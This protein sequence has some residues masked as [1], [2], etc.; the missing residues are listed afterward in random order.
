[1][2]DDVMKWKCFPYFCPFVRGIHL[3]CG[4]PHKGPVMW[5]FD[6]GFVVSLVNKLSN[7]QSSCRW[8][9]LNVISPKWHTCHRHQTCLSYPWGQCTRCG[10]IIP[11]TSLCLSVYLKK[12]LSLVQ[13]IIDAWLLVISTRPL[14]EPVL[15]YCG[16]D[17]C[18][19]IQ[20]NFKP[21]YN[22][23]HTRKWTWN[24]VCKTEAVLSQ[25]QCDK[26]SC[27]YL[28]SIICIVHIVI[29][30]QVMISLTVGMR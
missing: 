4:S 27:W 19:Q 25:L 9:E 28:L 23:S 12:K 10:S 26:K 13:I 1:M 30:L 17:S 14:S 2:H 22:N 21:K 16:S 3:S 5:I 6:V 8:F 7:K 20:W 24:V 15:T 11:M 29:P 18:G